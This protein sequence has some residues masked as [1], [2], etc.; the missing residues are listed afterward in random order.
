MAVNNIPVK[1]IPLAP[2]D[3]PTGTWEGKEYTPCQ[4]KSGSKDARIRTNQTYFAKIHGQWCL[5]TFSEV[6]YGWNF[7]NWGTSG[8]QLDSIED[9]YEVNVDSL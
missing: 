5:G 2:F 4:R 3:S 8:I 6:W 7:R 1:H 9:L